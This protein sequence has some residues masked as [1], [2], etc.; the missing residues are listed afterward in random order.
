[1]DYDSY[2]KEG[3]KSVKKLFQSGNLQNATIA[4]GQLLK[5]D[6]YNKKLMKLQREIEEEVLRVNLEKVKKEIKRTWGLWDERRYEELLQIYNK[7]Y[8]YAPQYDYLTELIS[9]AETALSDRQ[10]DERKK[11]IQDALNVI[12]KVF[13]EKRFG[14]TLLACNEL[15]IIDPRNEEA[16][17]ILQKT[18]EA[19]VEEKLKENERIVDSGDFER[20]LELYESLL[21]IDPKS[22]KLLKLIRDAEDH[23]SKKKTLLRRIQVNEGVKRIKDLFAAREYEK[24]IQ[25][26]EEL[27]LIDPKNLTGHLYKQKAVDTI[28]TENDAAVFKKL[29]ENLPLLKTEFLKNQGEF[30]RI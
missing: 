4:C 1:M 3:I 12:R 23:V 2:L 29:K 16:K 20:A 17:A 13:S 14:E 19:L 18:K 25:A 9:K 30:V 15:L 28:E 21:S 6:P 26:C 24:T 5:I 7:L 27:L 10:K 11:F 8:E 22:Q